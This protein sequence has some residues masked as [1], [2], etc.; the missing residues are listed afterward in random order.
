MGDMA[1]I[2][3]ALRDDKKENRLRNGKACDGCVQHHPKRSPSILMPGQRC[4]W[5]GFVRVKT[6]EI[7]I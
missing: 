4:R 5:C 7:K 3:N 2:Y 6:L 1:D